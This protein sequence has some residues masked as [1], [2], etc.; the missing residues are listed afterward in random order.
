M[1]IEVNAGLHGFVTNTAKTQ[2]NIRAWC[3]RGGHGIDGR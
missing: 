3:V 1:A 2:S